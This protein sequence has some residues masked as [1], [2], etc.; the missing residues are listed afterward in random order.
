[1][2][3]EQEPVEGCDP[4]EWVECEENDDEPARDVCTSCGLVRY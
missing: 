2:N 4:H 1:M 3:D